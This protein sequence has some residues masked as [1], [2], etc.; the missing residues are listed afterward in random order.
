[1]SFEACLFLSEMYCLGEAPLDGP[2]YQKAEELRE[3]GMALYDYY[4][5]GLN[6]LKSIV[7]KWPMV[8]L[9]RSTFIFDL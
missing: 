2:D 9:P 3:Y 1:M 5:T 8:L 7:V 6:N 4:R